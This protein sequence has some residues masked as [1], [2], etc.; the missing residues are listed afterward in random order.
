MMN[1]ARGNDSGIP[2]RQRKT[3]HFCSEILP[4]EWTASS[5]PAKRRHLK[6]RRLAS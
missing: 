3:M 6:A 5:S 2:A 1:A 4:A